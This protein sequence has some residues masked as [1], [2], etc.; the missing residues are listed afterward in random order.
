MVPASTSLLQRPTLLPGIIQ[1]ASEQATTPVFY[2]VGTYNLENLPNLDITQNHLSQA[3]KQNNPPIIEEPSPDTETKYGV[4]S[5]EKLPAVDEDKNIPSKALNPILRT[6]GKQF[7][8]L[9]FFPTINE[10]SLVPVENTLAVDKVLKWSP[11]FKVY[12]AVPTST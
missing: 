5:L 9:F 12:Q 7:E 8:P 4:L 1:P 6:N 10:E 11:K 2:N 3:L